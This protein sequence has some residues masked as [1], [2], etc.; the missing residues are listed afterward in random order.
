MCSGELSVG[1]GR[2]NVPWL[3]SRLANELFIRVFLLFKKKINIYYWKVFLPQRL[4]VCECLLVFLLL[5]FHFT[6]DANDDD[7]DG[8]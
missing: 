1:D 2:A 3:P 4:W 7:D 8:V 6:N 5:S